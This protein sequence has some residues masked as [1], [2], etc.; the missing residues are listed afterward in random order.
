M[1]HRAPYSNP[2]ARY[3]CA[4]TPCDPADAARVLAARG[5]ILRRLFGAASRGTASRGASSQLKLDLA[6]GEL[7]RPQT[8]RRR[9][10]YVAPRAADVFGSV[11]VRPVVVPERDVAVEPV[12][13]E[14]PPEEELQAEP[15]PALAADRSHACAI[16]TRQNHLIDGQNSRTKTV[17]AELSD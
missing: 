5:G 8:V 14:V 16:V 15:D 9:V 1:A 12:A 11:D 2:A 10:H 3:A 4:I 6:A 17:W 13:R 7:V